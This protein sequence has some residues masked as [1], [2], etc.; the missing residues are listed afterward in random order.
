[1]VFLHSHGV[2]TARVTKTAMGQTRPSETPLGGSS[3][4]PCDGSPGVGCLAPCPIASAA[5]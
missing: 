5:A 3:K 1:M 2:G 4:Q